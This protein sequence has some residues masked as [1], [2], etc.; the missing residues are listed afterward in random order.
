MGQ[1]ITNST[2]FFALRT[3]ENRK[4]L[5]ARRGRYSITFLWLQPDFILCHQIYL[6]KLSRH[7][8]PPKQAYKQVSRGFRTQTE[9]KHTGRDREPGTPQ[10]TGSQPDTAQ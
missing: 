9:V 4:Y 6:M 7:F 8:T 2:T 5:S 1:V 10:P 3:L